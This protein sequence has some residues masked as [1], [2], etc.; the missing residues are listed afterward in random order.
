MN[1]DLVHLK[2]T[3]AGESIRVQYSGRWTEWA[4]GETKLVPKGE[5]GHCMAYGINSGGQAVLQLLQGKESALALAESELAVAKN[6]VTNAKNALQEAQAALVT[7]DKRLTAVKAKRD[8]LVPDDPPPAPPA[9][10]PPA[11]KGDK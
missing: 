2:N 7:A 6:D 11:K 1:E 4:P 10:T 3:D 8:S 9:P 5:A